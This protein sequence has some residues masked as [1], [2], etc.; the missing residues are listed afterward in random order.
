MSAI[1]TMTDADVETLFAVVRIA[2]QV[3]MSVWEDAYYASL[4]ADPTK[5]EDEIQSYTKAKGMRVSQYLLTRS[6]MIVDRVNGDPN[7]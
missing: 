5:N 1:D 3:P 2:Y 4:L 6:R 7:G